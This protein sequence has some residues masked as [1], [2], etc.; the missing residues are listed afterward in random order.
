MTADEDYITPVPGPGPLPD[1]LLPAQHPLPLVR[2]HRGRPRRSSP[3]TPRARPRR[4]VSDEHARRSCRSSAAS[5][6]CPTTRSPASGGGTR[7]SRSP[8]PPTSSCSSRASGTTPAASPS[9]ARTS[10]TTRRRSWPSVRRIAADKSLELPDVLAQ[11]R[12]QRSSP[13]L[14]RCWAA[15]SRPGARTSTRRSPTW[16]A[17]CAWRTASSTPSRRSGTTRRGWPWARSC[18]PPG[19]AKEAETVYWDDLPLQP[20]ERLGALRPG[21]GAARPGPERRGGGRAGPLRQGLGARRREARPP[22]D[23]EERT[24]P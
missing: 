14:P 12:G 3:S 16:T 20:R 2:R 23:S 5:A 7:C 6:S 8:P 19:R 10:S 15:R 4:K 13:S 21:P 1:G 18:S 9:W 11:H 17:R 24:R 22:P